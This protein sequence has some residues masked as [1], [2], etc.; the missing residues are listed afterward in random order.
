M[1]PK[2]SVRFFIILFFYLFVLTALILPLVHAYSIGISPTKLIFDKKEKSLL[3]FNSN[4]ISSTYTIKGC[5]YNFIDLLR[6]GK[7]PA[8]SEREIV[9]RYNS[10]M[11][12][13]ISSCSFELFF[14]NN[15]Y[16]TALSI[17]V[18]FSSF[19]NPRQN[20]D[21]NFISGL[22]SSDM[23]DISQS[24]KRNTNS[25]IYLI[26]ASGIVFMIILFV[27]IKFL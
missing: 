2:Q 13:N 9:I 4:N 20:Y 25:R 10:A 14:A 5:E 6:N 7:I 12:K 15:I 27:I 24:D 8:L 26:I 3:I 11:N 19:S 17:P 21:S 18:I 1:I 22:F 23:S 16:A